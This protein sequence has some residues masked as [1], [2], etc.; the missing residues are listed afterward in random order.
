MITVLTALLFGGMVAWLCARRPWIAVMLSFLLIAYSW[1]VLSCTYLD[2]AGPVY[3][4]QLG[5][6]VGAGWSSLSIAL[7]DALS[8]AA[9]VLVFMAFSRAQRRAAPPLRAWSGAAEKRLRDLA[10]WTLIGMAAC[11]HIEM[12]SRGIVPL[13]EGME[14]YE[15]RDHFAGP[16]HLILMKYGQAI[17]GVLGLFF[18][19]GKARDQGA[20]Y[21]CLLAL[22]L[23][24]LHLLLAG[25]RFSAFYSYTCFFLLAVGA[26]AVGVES[27]RS[28]AGSG[29]AIL[30]MQ[31]RRMIGVS[32][33]LAVALAVAGIANSYMVVRADDEE[34][35]QDRIVERVLVQQGEMWYQTHQ[36]VFLDAG[37]NEAL[38]YDKLFND[39]IDPT[40]NTSI[41]YLMEES[42]GS[43]EARRV[44]E[45]GTQYAGGYPEILFELGGQ[46]GG[47]AL[48]FLTSCATALLC[49]VLIR[50]TM[51]GCLF[52]AVGAIF[53]IHVVMV[54]HIGGMLNFLI[55]STF[56]MKLAL[57]LLAM[58]WEFRDQRR[59]KAAI[60]S[61]FPSEQSA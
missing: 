29:P 18:F 12:F 3:S 21:R 43:E 23:I 33:L 14:R 57:M 5:A 20:D 39:P 35:S 34:S 2:L 41:Q 45:Q 19:I 46:V 17:A 58:A 11:L 4:R 52:T 60:S 47:F 25:H 7:A 38:T 36:R 31:E 50:A 32:I 16:L 28:M 54:L 55:H 27:S 42:L 6:D 61:P 8:L 10:A 40:F 9:M 13:F 30:G 22:G 44:L 49:W 15:Y 59:R 26:V 51:G 1:R 48:V 37:Q 24:Y 53:V 56:F